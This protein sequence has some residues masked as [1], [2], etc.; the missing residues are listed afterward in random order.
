MSRRREPEAVRPR[1]RAERLPP[2]SALNLSTAQPELSPQQ[3]ASQKPAAELPPLQPPEI[4]LEAARSLTEWAP[5]QSPGRSAASLQLR[6]P[7]EAEQSQSAALAGVAERSFA[8]RAE[9]ERLPAMQPVRQVRLAVLARAASPPPPGPLMQPEPAPL[10]ASEEQQPPDADSPL[11]LQ[12]LPCASESRAS[13]R[14]ASRPATS[15]S[16]V[17]AHCC[18]SGFAARRSR[19]CRAA[20]MRAHA[21]PHRLRANS[22]GSSFRLRQLLSEHPEFPGS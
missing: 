7:R 3:L 19:G 22:N 2:P 10:G 18:S 12:P 11:R 15:R 8:V 5:S 16:S 14:P 21:R 13:R 6:E 17:F 9:P 20:N 1:L 4:R